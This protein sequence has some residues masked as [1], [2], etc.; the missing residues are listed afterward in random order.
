M[1]GWALLCF[2]RGDQGGEVCWDGRQCLFCLPPVEVR[3]SPG[4]KPLLAA[5]PSEGWLFHLVSLIR[6]ILE[7]SPPMSSPLFF[8]AIWRM[9]NQ[10]A[11]S[12]LFGKVWGSCTHGNA[13][14]FRAASHEIWAFKQKLCWRGCH[15]KS[16]TLS[17]EFVSLC[18]TPDPELRA[19]ECLHGKGLPRF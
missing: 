18:F 14:R 17:L 15:E 16:P 9:R 4:M 7:A 13:P 19:E 3:V 12:D 10:R 11:T 6:W 5:S 1:F 8:S 2:H